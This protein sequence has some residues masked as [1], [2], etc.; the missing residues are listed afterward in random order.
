VGPLLDQL[1]H[2]CHVFEFRGE[3]YRIRQS[4]QRQQQMAVSGLATLSILIPK[5]EELP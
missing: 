5:D 4:M 1:T 2:R 3:S